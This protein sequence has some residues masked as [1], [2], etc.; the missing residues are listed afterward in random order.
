M[1]EKNVIPYINTKQEGYMDDNYLYI[2]NEGPI[3]LQA[4]IDTVWKDIPAVVKSNNMLFSKDKKTGIGA[5]DRA[6]VYILSQFMN[7]GV[8][9]LFT[10][11]EES[12]GFGM[13]AFLRDFKDFSHIKLAIAVD[14]H[15]VGDYVTYNSLPDQVH[16]Y[17]RSFGFNEVEG[18]FSDIALFTDTTRIPSVNLS[19]GYHREHTVNEYLCID[20]ME[21]TINRIKQMIKRPINKKYKVKKPKWN[22]YKY[23]YYDNSQSGD[24]CEMCS[25]RLG[26]GW[27]K[28]G[29]GYFW[30]CNE[31]MVDFPLEWTEN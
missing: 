14:R 31:C 10:N 6:G 22:A 23:P 9:L 16:S 30:L 24:L 1:H 2:P 19:C 21:L 13:D 11:H 29:S 4:H 7:S 15:G 25:N 28:S 3:L 17:V 5:D 8:S 20:E 12:G 26:I 18:S 27:A